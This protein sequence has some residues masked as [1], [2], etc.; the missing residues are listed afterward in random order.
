[1]ELIT[2]IQ[3]G[4]IA[5]KAACHITRWKL[6]LSNDDNLC[7]AF[8]VNVDIFN[9]MSGNPQSTALARRVNL[10]TQ[11]K[12]GLA[13]RGPKTWQWDSGNTDINDTINENEFIAMHIICNSTSQKTVFKWHF[14]MYW[15]ADEDWYSNVNPT[16]GGGE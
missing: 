14:E 1:M 8:T 16:I 4:L 7:S 5:P 9:D 2:I 15:H 12:S 10:T 3:T 6:W 13:A 11:S